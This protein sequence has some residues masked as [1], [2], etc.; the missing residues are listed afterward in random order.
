[1]SLAAQLIEHDLVDGYRL[2]IEPILLSGG[3]RIFPMAARPERS[4]WFG[5]S[6]RDGRPDLHLP[7]HVVNRRS[8]AI[9]ANSET[10]SCGRRHNR[11]AL[12]HVSASGVSNETNIEG[13]T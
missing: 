5:D 8:S 12:W 13:G 1:M 4:G 6:D 2:M 10:Q 7:S 11:Y 9:R 3:K